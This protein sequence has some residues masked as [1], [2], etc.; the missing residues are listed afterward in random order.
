MSSVEKVQYKVGISKSEIEDILNVSLAQ[1]DIERIL[2][3]EG[4]SYEIVSPRKKVVEM[5]K[6]YVGVPYKYG[7]SVL[8]DGGHAF[9]CSSFTARVYVDAGI[10]IPRIS[11]DQYVSGVVVEE[12][13]LRPGDAIYANSGIVKRIIYYE[14]KEF[15]KGTKVPE[16]V[17]HCGVYIGNGEVAHATEKFG[18][19]IIEQLK[20]SEGFKNIVGYRSHVPS[21]EERFIIHVPLERIDIRTKEDMAKEIGR[22]M[23]AFK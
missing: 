10:S 4:F 8:R 19:V 13:D 1:K 23:Q 16:G 17:D 3:Q 21:E 14:T 11:V 2:A 18:K 9:D 7:A 5:V 20:E 15:L 12:K 22:A 6:R